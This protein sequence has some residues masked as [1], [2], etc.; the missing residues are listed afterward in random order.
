M[1]ITIAIAQYFW[2]KNAIWFSFP[3][4][5]IYIFFINTAIMRKK[6]PYS[7][8]LWS[9]FSRIRTGYREI[10]I[11]PYSVRMRENADQN[12]PDY[13]HF[14]RSVKVTI[15][16]YLKK[17]F[18]KKI[19]KLRVSCREVFGIKFRNI[20]RKMLIITYW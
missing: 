7:G 9:A 16:S 20:K 8:L 5:S 19:A 2:L 11:S 18:F 4:T 3:L 17:F 10:L 1:T 13:G 14:S 6:C 12:N 15:W